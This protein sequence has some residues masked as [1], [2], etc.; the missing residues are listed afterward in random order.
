[1]GSSIM[2]DIVVDITGID[3]QFTHK[4][5]YEHN[6]APRRSEAVNRSEQ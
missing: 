1:M 6:G 4:G 2:A 3:Y 5:E